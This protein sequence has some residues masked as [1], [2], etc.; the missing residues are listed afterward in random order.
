MLCVT[1]TIVVS[2]STAAT[3]GCKHVEGRVLVKIK[4]GLVISQGTSP[5]ETGIP[6]LDSLNKLYLCTAFEPLLPYIKNTLPDPVNPLS[7]TYLVT[8]KAVV[9]LDQIIEAYLS[10]GLFEYV[11]PDY[12]VEGSSSETSTI[13][14]DQYF[15]RQWALHNDGT[16]TM[17]GTF[18]PKDDA[19][20]DM[21]EAW[22]IEQGDT[23]VIIALLDSGCK[24]D[25]P[26]LL[27]RLWKNSAEIPANNLDDDENGYVDDVNGWDFIN[28]DNDPNDDGGHGTRMAGIIGANANNATGFAG[29]N[30][31]A[32]IMVVKVLDND[33]KGNSTVTSKGIVY[34]VKMKANI[35]NMSLA[36]LNYTKTEHDAVQ[37]ADKNNVLII[38]GTG[39]SNTE[40]IS[41]PAAFDEVLAVGTTGPDDKRYSVDD[42]TGSNY[43]AEIDI[44][45][46]GVYIF[47]LDY[48]DDNKYNLYSSGTSDAAAYTTGVASLLL[49]KN[50]HLTPAQLKSILEQSADDLVGDPAEDV[51]GWDKYFGWGRLNAH[52]ALTLASSVKKACYTPQQ[53]AVTQTKKA[54]MFKRPLRTLSSTWYTV[55]GRRLSGSGKNTVTT[56]AA[57]GVIIGKQGGRGTDNGR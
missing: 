9:S 39:N 38:T 56:P 22:E 51:R 45:A 13:P 34:A 32:R 2:A 49:S 8:Y 24:M 52:K 12:L 18:S 50:P 42:S 48:K 41:Y 5:C 40:K 10:T 15:N 4:E 23:S 31:N 16:F 55:N 20:I 36:G 37:Y 47:G 29:V 11:E 14:N 46:P 17:G 7:R 33:G 53:L 30:P 26:E 1:L 54:V 6:K 25:H 43:G 3:K 44:T 27:G 57:A 28:N 19:D 35:I 21:P